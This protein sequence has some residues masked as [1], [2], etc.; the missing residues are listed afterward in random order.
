[1]SRVALV[2]WVLVGCTPATEPPPA[3]PVD[4]RRALAEA[5]PEAAAKALRALPE[6][7]Q[8]GAALAYGEGAGTREGLEALVLRSGALPVSLRRTFMNGAAH[9][10]APPEGEA[11]GAVVRSIEATVPAPDRRTFHNGVLISFA[12]AAGGDP[13]VV[14]PYARRYEEALGRLPLDGVRIGL[15]R[16]RGVD[17]ADAV[18]VAAEYP[19]AWQPALYE[20]LGWRAGDDADRWLS[21]VCPVVAEVPPASR[22]H[23]VHGAARGR[24]LRVGWTDPGEA[25]VLAERVRGNACGCEAQGWRGVAWGLALTWDHRPNQAENRARQLPEGGPR[26][27]VRRELGTLFGGRRGAPWELPGG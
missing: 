10:W 20:E 23:F 2:W 8:F 4:P 17:L 19:E 11:V 21:G 13:D 12:E 16:A 3:E 7:E 15:Q 22:C 9:T 25:A 24:T 5:S 14:V 27:A 18:A 6:A 1:M 26:E